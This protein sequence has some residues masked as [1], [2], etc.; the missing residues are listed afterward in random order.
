[1]L[2]LFGSVRA[3]SGGIQDCQNHL[4]V[5]VS[6]KLVESSGK[7][8]R[9]YIFIF[10]ISLVLHSTRQLLIIFVWIIHTWNKNTW[11]KYIK[12]CLPAGEKE[13]LFLIFRI[14]AEVYND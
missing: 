5:L 12:F 14:L 10:Y 11:I 4:D 9:M 13:N 2:F 8:V 7:L 6:N 1:M 3:P